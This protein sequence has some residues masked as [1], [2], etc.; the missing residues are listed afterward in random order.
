M[1]NLI[2]YDQKE[3]QH[4]VKYHDFYQVL[5]YA[6][7]VLMIFFMFLWTVQK[8]STEYYKNVINIQDSC[9]TNALQEQKL[10]IDTAKWYREMGVKFENNFDN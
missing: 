7:F 10:S 8:D 4:K 6:L 3:L 2:D 5:S 9:Y 1:K